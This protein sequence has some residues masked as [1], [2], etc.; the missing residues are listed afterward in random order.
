MA[1]YSRPLSKSEL[2]FI[3]RQKLRI[4]IWCGVLVCF[5]LAA[6]VGIFWLLSNSG[7]H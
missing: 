7:P 4:I 3:R 1:G 6:M 2:R 5:V